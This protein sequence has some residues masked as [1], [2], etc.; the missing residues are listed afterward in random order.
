MAKLDK[1][2]ATICYDGVWMTLVQTSFN[3]YTLDG[4]RIIGGSLLSEI[5]K[6]AEELK[7]S[8]NDGN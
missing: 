8:D 2:W 4:K 7:E 1:G 5:R 3:Q 6:R